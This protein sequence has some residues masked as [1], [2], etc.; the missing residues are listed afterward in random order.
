VRRSEGGVLR[1]GWFATGRGETS[2]KLL[3]AAVD[4]IREGRLDAEIAFVFSNRQP[5][6]F[7]ITDAFFNQVRSYGIP[8]VTLSDQR[9]RRE[10]GGE[11]ARAGQP[12]PAWR[13]DYDR[14]V[15]GLLEPYAWD[16][17][18]LAG[19][20]LITTPP[21]LES[22][23]LL[24]L[25][26]AAPGQP[27]GTWQEVIWQLI[28]GRVRHGGVRIHL[29]TPELDEGPIVTYCTY[30][31]RGATIDLLWRAAESRPV[32]EIRD[33]EGE[34]NPLF[35]EIRRRG[36]ARELPLVIE[37]LRAFA[38]QRLRV[39]DGRIMAGTTKIV[40]GFDLTPE[41]ESSLAK[42]TVA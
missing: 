4:A 21:L 9:F 13:T 40:G 31:L 26:P 14:A 22:H 11:A 36:L 7:Q 30:P 17:G 15:V 2:P 8:L 27:A 41:I 29:V 16:V 24:N 25:H 18:M 19:Y 12:L 1:I 35:Q 28:E 32:A 34:T 10:A 6:Q 37:T 38:D 23:T 42:A 5:G 33:S 3:R 20:M 39:E